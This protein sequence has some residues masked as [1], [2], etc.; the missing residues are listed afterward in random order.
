MI[1]LEKAL[2]ATP[3]VSGVS[4]DHTGAASSVSGNGLE[5]G[6]GAGGRIVAAPIAFEDAS[7]F[8]RQLHRHH[9]PP[10]GH[11]FSIAAMIADRLVGVVIVGR[12]VARRRDDGM[13]LEVTRLCT[14]GTPN[15]CSFLYGA[16][17]RAAFALGYRRIGTYILK[18]EP[19]TSLVAAGWKMIAETPGKSWSVP[20]RPRA[21][22][23][24]IEPK[25]L[26]ERTA[27]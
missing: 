27:A 26:F 2:T 24:P 19:G 9:T 4:S 23:H 7:E 10:Q 18:R 8:V 16:A 22:K 12:P 1:P 15:A 11:K 6:G 21:D 5:C 25:L 17:A 14:D 13:T 20:S 3:D